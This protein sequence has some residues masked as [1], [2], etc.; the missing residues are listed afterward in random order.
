MRVGTDDDLLSFLFQCCLQ[1]ADDLG[2]SHPGCSCDCRTSIQKGI[3]HDVCL[4]LIER[5]VAGIN[6]FLGHALGLVISK[7]LNERPF[8][9]TLVPA[10]PI[11][12]D[13][14]LEALSVSSISLA[15]YWHFLPFFDVFEMVDVALNA[16][17][18]L[19]AANFFELSHGI[20]RPYK[21]ETVDATAKRHDSR[22][23]RDQ[24]PRS[25]HAPLLVEKTEQ[26]YGQHCPVVV[27][28]ALAHHDCA[29]RPEMLDGDWSWHVLFPVRH[30]GVV[31]PTL[32]LGPNANG[33]EDH[34][35]VP[36]T[37]LESLPRVDE[38]L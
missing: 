29:F 16:I 11:H 38:V 15:A 21:I 30:A 6:H 23:S 10:S 24:L 13:L 36:T 8:G 34:L 20:L 4:R 3:Q 33:R 25:V 22:D 18:S 1:R 27:Q 9:T 2:F 26:R 35:L 5:A 14:G 28:P 37:L 31:R 17:V 32:L 12:L 19:F 7:G